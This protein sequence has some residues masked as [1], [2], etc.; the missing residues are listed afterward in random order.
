MWLEFWRDAWADTDGFVGEG[1]HTAR[2]GLGIGGTYLS[3]HHG[4]DWELEEN[5]IFNL[6]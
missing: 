1:Y 2:G 3:F 4:E 6:K 5:E